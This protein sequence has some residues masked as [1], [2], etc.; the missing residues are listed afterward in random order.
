MTI[1]HR[2]YLKGF[3]RRSLRSRTHYYQPAVDFGDVRDA[4]VTGVVAQFFGGSRDNLMR[5][6]D[7]DRDAARDQQ[8][9]STSR[10]LDETL[11]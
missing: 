5:F 6:L 11:L 2:L 4:A 7:D 10:S 3:L 9:S 1:M 8:P